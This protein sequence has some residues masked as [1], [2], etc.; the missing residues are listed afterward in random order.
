[1]YE[2]TV[3]SR[4]RW[5]RIQ[6]LFNGASTV[7]EGDRNAW[8]AEKCGA[9]V[10][11]R[12]HVAALLSSSTDADSVF[13]VRVD[14]AI[15][16]SMLELDALEPGRM[17]GRYRVVRLLG[18]GGMGSVYLAARADEQFDQ[19]VALKLIGSSLPGSALTRR[20]RAERQILAHLNHPNIAR[21]LDGGASSDGVPYL[22]MEYVDGIRIDT[23][24]ERERLGVPERLRLF[25]QVCAAVQYAHQN[26]IV[27]R[28]IKPSNIL[29]TPDGT[30]KLL[31]FGIAKLLDPQQTG[32]SDGLTRIQERVLTP[33]HASP[34]QL[35]GDPVGT[36]SDVYSLGV[37]LYEL[38][39]GVRPF[40]LLGR[41]IEES[42]HVIRTIQ[43]QKPSAAIE[44]RN[45]ANG[46][47]RALS[48]ALVGDLDNI[49]LR[50][51]HKESQRRY[52]SAAALSDDIHNF[53]S[54]RPVQARPDAWTYRLGKFARRNS[55]ALAATVAVALA[56]TILVG[57]YTARV[58]AERDTAERERLTA[59]AVSQFMED[60]FRVANPSESRGNSVTVREVL[61]AGVKRIDTDLQAQPRVQ[62]TLLRTLGEVY[63]G[64]GLWEQAR[65]LLERAV[66]RERA[67]FG[68]DHIELSE[69]LAALAGAHHN[70]NHFEVE[71]QLYQEA[72][73]IRR[74]LRRD[75][76]AE[77]ATLLNDIAGGLRAQQRFSEALD[78]HNQAEVIARALTPAQPEVL[79]HVLQGYS[80]TY[81]LTGE[82]K[83]SE[84]FARESL[85]MV[86]DGIHDGNELYP[87]SIFALAE[88]LRRQY[89]L[90][91][92]EELQRKLLE[93]QTKRM[94]ADAPLVARSW[95]NLSHVLRAGGKYPQSEE[96]LRHAIGIFHKQFGERN[97]DLATSYHNLGALQ[98]EAGLPKQSLPW[99]RQ[100][101]SLKKELTSPRSPH[102][103]STLLEI[104]AA[105]RELHDYPE[106]EKTLIEAEQ[107]AK[108]AYE[109]GDKRHALVL[110][111]RA[112]FELARD[113]VAEAQAAARTGLGLVDEQD[114]GRM[115]TAQCLLAEALVRSGNRP[116]ALRLLKEALATRE[117]IMPASHWM[118]ADAQS[119]IG[120][121]LALE[122]SVEAVA[123]L[124]KSV[125]RLR[126]T[127]PA[128]DGALLAA[129][130]RLDSY[131]TRDGGIAKAARSLR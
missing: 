30:P 93:V 59:A 61:D 108:E 54:D 36:V 71:A 84:R 69:A 85:E 26:L 23:Y 79:G 49:V 73:K 78:Y 80:M 19:Q 88:S 109:S 42:A 129:E 44:T 82:Y 41:T 76:D 120:E 46:S 24:C 58:T 4:E 28:D 103:V 1:M 101:L 75:N 31:D 97:F 68:D 66:S 105:Q 32:G 45:N 27:H 13:D 16:G 118:I 64:L 47:A 83:L 90:E 70:L 14:S 48:R 12:D 112:R 8:L 3:M 37:L 111:E 21:L 38:L 35:R 116:E 17:V 5:E 57:Y 102:L 81:L 20:F 131:Q 22:A 115:A 130:R 126:E 100:S 119:R 52:Q 2:S 39:T 92:S 122:G 94:G 7:G 123:M 87:N 56:T 121:V 9:D 10:G 15:A 6:E 110:L 91:E 113:H 11:L 98:N 104:S 107:L 51:M 50:A 114:P 89:K 43:P 33:E 25:Q 74:A 65:E 55:G 96:A 117:R 106:A 63:S 72:W 86:R 18:R 62:I 124:T 95:N 67:S 125:A 127:R 77:S 128:G 60:V 40:V 34:E 29:V 53:L 99:L